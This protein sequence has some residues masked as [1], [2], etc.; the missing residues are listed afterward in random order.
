LF[1]VDF[2]CGPSSSPNPH[3][4]LERKSHALSAC[5]KVATDSE[6]AEI[7][8]GS[9]RSQGVFPRIAPGEYEYTHG[10]AIDF[11]AAIHPTK[12]GLAKY[13]SQI[14]EKITGRSG[15][16]WLTATSRQSLE[17]TNPR[18][19][20]ANNGAPDST[21]SQASNP[22]PIDAGQDCA[23][24][25]RICCVGQKLFMDLDIHFIGR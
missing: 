16:K 17:Q 25:T 2:E 10:N 8:L 23:L 13:S 21:L 20:Y 22:I 14:V 5:G 3:R 12:L 11:V 4:R 7:P 9:E 24:D 15:R 19:A 6:E 18:A 1:A